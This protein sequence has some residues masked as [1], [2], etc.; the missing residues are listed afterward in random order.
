MTLQNTLSTI[1]VFQKDTSRFMT[2]QRGRKG[3]DQPEPIWS[4]RPR[5]WSAWM[6]RVSSALCKIRNDPR[7]ISYYFLSSD[8]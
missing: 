5:C 8:V 3:A 1:M 2:K 6:V 4:S 7:I